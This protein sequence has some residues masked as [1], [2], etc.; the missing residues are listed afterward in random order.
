MEKNPTLFKAEDVPPHV[1]TKKKKT[2]NVMTLSSVL[3]YCELNIEQIKNMPIY[4]CLKLIM[5]FN[6]AWTK[7]MPFHTKQLICKW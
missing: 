7:V 1:K 2:K 4:L 6:V 5:Q 3:G